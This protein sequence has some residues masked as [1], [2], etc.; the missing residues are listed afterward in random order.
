MSK[1]VVMMPC[2]VLEERFGLLNKRLKA[3][4]F[5]AALPVQNQPDMN[6]SD[7]GVRKSYLDLPVLGNVLQQDRP[8]QKKQAALEPE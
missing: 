8:V 6:G 5:N 1:S 2:P 3:R 4:M 7:S